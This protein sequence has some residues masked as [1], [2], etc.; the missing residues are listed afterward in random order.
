M[1]SKAL[2][3]IDHHLTFETHFLNDR[4]V[5]RS[6]Q[7]TLIYTIFI[8]QCRCL[9]VYSHASHHLITL[10]RRWQIRGRVMFNAPHSAISGC[11]FTFVH[12]KA[13]SRWLRKPHKRF[14]LSATDSFLFTSKRVMN[15]HTLE[16]VPT[17]TGWSPQSVRGKKTFFCFLPLNEILN[18]FCFLHEIQHKRQSSRFL[19]CWNQQR[20]NTNKR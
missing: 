15:V 19:L 18:I 12:H 1:F 5:I 9:H 8:N 20:E 14:R 4:I 6:L 7:W 2:T 13:A 11:L 17:F 16:W 3:N 10:Q